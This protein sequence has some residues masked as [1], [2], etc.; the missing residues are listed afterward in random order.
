MR[1]RGGA[2]SRTSEPPINRHTALTCAPSGTTRRKHCPERWCSDD[3]GFD[4]ETHH[5]PKPTAG[6][7][8]RRH[9]DRADQRSACHVRPLRPPPGGCASP[10]ASV[11]SGGRR[12][13]GRPAGSDPGRAG[14]PRPLRSSG[15]PAGPRVSAGSWRSPARNGTACRGRAQRGTARG[16]PRRH[17]CV[18]AP[19]RGRPAR[20]VPAPPRCRSRSRPPAALAGPCGGGCP[21][22]ASGTGSTAT[23][24]APAD[25]V[26]GAR[27]PQGHRSR[28]RGTHRLRA[29][30]WHHRPPCTPLRTAV[31]LAPSA[32]DR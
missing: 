29:P 7:D 1:S 27:A 19:C 3:D 31:R 2:L 30:R 10:G 21:R 28:W 26:A 20:V 11:L 22:P 17:G 23:A 8:L 9:P 6:A 14:E 13:R 5:P 4:G 32:S 24:A 15:P 18:G 25:G 16:W 12:R